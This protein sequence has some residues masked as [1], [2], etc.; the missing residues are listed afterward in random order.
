MP[1]AQTS[2]FS[3]F[4]SSILSCI[5]RIP[6]PTLTIGLGQR[7]GGRVRNGK[8][9]DRHNDLAVAHIASLTSI[10]SYPSSHPPLPTAPI[11]T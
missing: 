4:S 5:F 7:R 3:D 8:H 2:Q 1:Q 11:S 9:I 10:P 6:Q